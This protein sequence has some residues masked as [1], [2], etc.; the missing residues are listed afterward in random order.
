MTVPP[1]GD[2]SDEVLLA[3]CALGD[4]RALAQLFRRHHAAV[5][6]VAAR[7]LPRGA[8]P[9]DVLQQ[10]FLAAWSRA[11]RFRGESSVLAWLLA[12]A[13]NLA[14][15]QRRSERRHLLVLQSLQRQPPPA[16][17]PLETSTERNDQLR[18][19]KDALQR[20]P[21]RLRVVY[22]MCDGEDLPRVEVAR[23]LGLPEGTVRRRLHAARKHL[24]ALLEEEG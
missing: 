9:E 10:T 18:R 23:A 1:P 8:D 21:H 2:P 22:L 4:R 17:E 7:M 16:A 15:K 24:L 13:A 12:I 3:A 6:R 5:H 11:G 14:W 19:V 20:L